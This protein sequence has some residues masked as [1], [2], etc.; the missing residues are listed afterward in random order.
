MSWGRTNAPRLT[1]A[2]RD[3]ILR[4]ARTVA[5]LGHYLQLLLR[6]SLT[7]ALEIITP[8]SALAPAIV[9]FRLRTRSQLEVAVL[10]HLVNLTPGT[11]VLEIRNR[12]SSLFVHAMHAADP[13]EL[14][15]DLG[16]LEARLLHAI[17]PPRRE[18]T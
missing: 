7:V 4:V 9:E 11:L 5:F 18:I 15:R 8:G 16:D 6:A 1:A 10:A 14:R 3:G 13:D 12:P 17:R 2:V